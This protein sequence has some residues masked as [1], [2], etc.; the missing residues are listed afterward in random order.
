VLKE[1]TRILIA[2]GGTGG[3]VFPAIAIADEIKKMNTNTEFMFAGTREKIEAQVVP[4]KG[5][6][7]TF[8]WI[9]GLHRSLRIENLLFPI[10]VV[11]SFFQS[12]F[13]IKKFQPDVVVGTGGYVCGT[14]LFVASMLGYPIIVHESN[15]LPGITTRML[16]KRATRIFTAF[17]A[18]TRWLKRKD[19]ITC[20]GTPTRDVLGKISRKDG[21]R[22]FNFDPS[23]K[24]VFVFG[25]SL[26]A[27]S[28][29]QAIKNLVRDL[30][31]AD[32]QL[33]WQTGSTDASI[34]DEWK[35]MKNCWVNTFIDKIEYAYAAADIV[36]CR[37][38]ATTLAELTRLGKAAILVPYPHAASDHQTFNAHT[39]ADAGAAVMIADQD[40]QAKLK[41]ELIA[42]LSNDERREQMNEASRILGRPNASKEIAQRILDLAKE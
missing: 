39:L 6:A 30:V 27:T 23:K 38:G 28:I 36:I 33:I 31:K 9:S 18:T 37:A 12:F 25:G 14:V 7:I 10:K 8:I 21:A 32:I 17:D 24:T 40:V 41:D 4:Q 5:Y 22:F 42:I 3:H 15:S 11:V 26:G 34:A 16:S 13:L 1:K 19:N 20:I 2:A 35:V 29:N